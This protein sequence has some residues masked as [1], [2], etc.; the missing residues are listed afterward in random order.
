[1]YVKY[2]FLLN[3]IELIKQSI[4]NFK[5]S[6]N[7]KLSQMQ[8]TTTQIQKIVNSFKRDT[9][10]LLD[11]L[12][13]ESI[14]TR[15]IMF[16]HDSTNASHINDNQEMFQAFYSADKIYKSRYRQ[17]DKEL[18]ERINE[19]EFRIQDIEFKIKKTK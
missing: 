18:L 9:E 4:Y 3:E 11:D 16:D 2:T 7:S 10:R 17:T 12:W 1:M 14:D 19:L 15:T 5:D 13:R 8:D 6:T